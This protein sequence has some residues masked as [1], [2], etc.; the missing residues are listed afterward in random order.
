MQSF[1]GRGREGRRR[2]MIGGPN[3]EDVEKRLVAV[4][5]QQNVGAVCLGTHAEVR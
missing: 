4:Q 2:A 3:E 1:E 5:K